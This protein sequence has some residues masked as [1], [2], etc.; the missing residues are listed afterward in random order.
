MR[1]LIVAIAAVSSARAIALMQLLTD[2]APYVN[3]HCI[4][5]A[6]IRQVCLQ[7]AGLAALN[8]KPAAARQP[9]PDHPV[10]RPSDP[11]QAALDPGSLMVLAEHALPSTP[12]NSPAAPGHKASGST[13][14]AAAAMRVAAGARDAL[15]RSL[16]SGLGVSSNQEF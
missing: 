14:L 2:L 16:S 11:T 8:P 4:A 12:A 6:L 10:Q 5:G 15:L 9:A 7:G 13:S 3:S 1:I